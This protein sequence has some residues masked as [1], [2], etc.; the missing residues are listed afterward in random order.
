[1]NCNEFFFYVMQEKFNFI[2]D[3]EHHFG[4]LDLIIRGIDR[5]AADIYRD[6]KY[7]LHRAYKNNVL[8]GGIA[9]VR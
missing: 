7:N 9:R 5:E 2:Y 8:I 1:M 6:W 4:D 3:V